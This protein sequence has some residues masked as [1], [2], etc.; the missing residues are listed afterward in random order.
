MIETLKNAWKIKDL[1]RKILFTLFIIVI[2]RVGMAIPVPFI[3]QA[4][5]IAD[6]GNN[7]I[8]GA[9]SLLSA[10]AEKKENPPVRRP[11]G[12]ILIG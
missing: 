9:F 3:D 7:E 2:F 8:L 4:K 5:L 1:R 10:I 12:K 11:N 6:A